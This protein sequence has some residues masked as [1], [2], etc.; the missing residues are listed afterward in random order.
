MMWRGIWVIL[1]CLMWG[2]VAHAQEA[3]PDVDSAVCESPFVASEMLGDDVSVLTVEDAFYTSA[4]FAERVQFAFAYALI[5]YEVRVAQIQEIATTTGADEATLLSFDT[6]LQT[7]R[8]EIEIPATLG[9]RVLND[10][11]EDAVVWAYAADNGLA[12]TAEDVTTIQDQFFRIGVDIASEDRESTIAQFRTRILGN[13]GTEASLDAFFCRLAI[14]DVVRTAVI[15]TGEE[16]LFVDAAHILVSSED[17]ARD[18]IA[19]L[20]DDD[21]SDTFAQYAIDLSLDTGTATRGGELGFSPVAIY[22]APFAEAIREADI[23]LLLEPVETQFG[24]HVIR[25]NAREI[26]AVEGVQREQILSSEFDM[27][28][29]EQLETVLVL[30][31]DDWETFLP[32]LPTVLFQ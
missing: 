17:T 12:I 6:G 24:W 32:E 4:Q 27:W 14:Y 28:R 13:G 16:A 25:V 8:E 23:G 9:N 11:A 15:G 2:V 18:L 29:A 20:T 5:R 30:R 3:T 1:L 21:A 22:V 10:I 19:L 31:A 7:L 26:R